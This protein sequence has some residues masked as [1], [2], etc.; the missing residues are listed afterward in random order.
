MKAGIDYYTATLSF[1]Q[2]RV[3]RY[4][5]RLTFLNDRPEWLRVYERRGGQNVK[6]LRDLRPV[7]GGTDTS[8]YLDAGRDVPAAS[9]RIYVFSRQPRKIPRKKGL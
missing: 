1:A 8:E 5:V 6:L 3:P 2:D 7:R 9:A 4:A